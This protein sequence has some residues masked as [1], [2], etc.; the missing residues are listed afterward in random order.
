M[1]ETNTKRIY[2]K[3]DGTIP[4]YDGPARAIITFTEFSFDEGMSP[5]KVCGVIH[6]WVDREIYQPLL[7]HSDFFGHENFTIFVK[8]G[9]TGRT[10]WYGRGTTDNLGGRI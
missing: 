5:D 4:K 10:L 2:F 6:R 1:N 8:E 9:E 3:F 7:R